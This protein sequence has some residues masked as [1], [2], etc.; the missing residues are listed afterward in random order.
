MVTEAMFLRA[1]IRKK[2]G[3]QHRYFSVVENR[4]VGQ[5]KTAQR[6]VLYLGE[7]ND[8][9]EAVWRETLEVFDEHQQQ[10][11]TLSLFPDD[12]EIPAEASD[13][14]Q[15]K[16]SEM[17]LR[18]PRAFGNC[19]L[20]CVLWRQLRLEEFWEEKLSEAVKRETV[21]WAKVL[22]LLV[23]NRLIDP[24]S[25]FRVHRQWFDQSAMAELLEADF[26]VAEKDRLY[27]CLDRIV[28]HKP[29]LF[30]HLRER[31]QDLFQAQFDVLLYDLTSTYIEGEGEQ[32]PKAKYGYSR[33]QR[34]D[35]KQ[36]VIALVITPEGLPLAYEVMDGN[37]S[38]RT[39]LR[40]FLDK[41]E[42]SYGR[43]R[44]VWV[45][46]RG[47]P[48]EAV[49]EEMRTSERAVFY[50]VGTSRSKIRQYEKKWLDLPWQKVRDAVEVKLFA[51]AGE[52]YVLAKSEGRGAKERAM[53]R[54]KLARLLR[55]LRALQRS[56][57]RRDQLLLR[58]GAARKEAGSV[59]RFLQIQV[60]REGEAVMRHSFHFRVD[61]TKL[62]A[63]ELQ[64][65]HYLL[66][67]NLVGEDPAVLWERYVQLAQIEAAFK[68]MKSELGI[69]PL[70][71]QLGHRVE[72]HILVAF[73][74]Y[75]LLITLKNRLQA[76]A[77]GLTPKAVLEK[78]ATIQMLDVW[79]PTT[80]GRWLVMPRFTQP[81]ADQAILLHKL[82][83]DLPQQPPPRIKTR[84]PE[85]PQEALRL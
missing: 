52:L 68:A 61:Q 11:T 60:P 50:L 55:K 66:R 65:G 1:K 46:D 35:C 15:V 24:G 74:A 25:E 84:V 69:R 70:Y 14:I 20:G 59:Y 80:D 47:I 54:K 76:L 36:V 37:T 56:G 21:P 53:R 44:R 73:L 79:L 43:A 19:W 29:A 9:Q 49:L 12:R 13:S 34:F 16:L 33:D 3:K 85:F 4:R 2:D 48:T 5:N 28:E 45:M 27:R 83:L 64:D 39:T 18:R 57:P 8:N 40:S 41:I 26:A 75:C 42:A 10:Y 82:K 71:H 32:I 17:V 72:A 51:E 7:I 23:V 67:S 30:Q 62:K 31:W 6:T 38:D 81:E 63:A 58:M 77:P 22:Q 78:L